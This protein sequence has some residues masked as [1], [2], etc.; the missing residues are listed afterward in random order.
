MKFSA[1]WIDEAVNAAP[2]ERATVADLRLWLSGQNVT[3]HFAGER[4]ADYVTIALYGIAHGLAHDWWT[5]FGGRDRTVSLMRFRS[6][7]LVPDIR[8]SFDGAAFDVYADQHS[9]QNE[10]VRFWAGA[11][12]TM[13]RRDAET[14]LDDLMNEI[15]GRL[16]RC[17][18]SDTSATLR[19]ARVRSSRESDEAQFC[20]AAGALGLD[21]Y[22]IDEMSAAAIQQSENLFQNEALIEF[23]AG[24]RH[25]EKTK[26][27]D[28]VEHVKC[29][30]RYKSHVPELKDIAKQAQAHA[31]VRPS[32]KAWSLGYRRARA[33]RKA[34]GIGLQHRYRSFRDLAKSLGASPAY[35]IA[36]KIDG[37][38]ALRHD[39]ANGLHIHLRS[40]SGPQETKASYLFTFAR[41]VGDAVCF[42]EAELAPV[43]DLHSAHR[44]AA[45]RAFAAD[46]APYLPSFITGLCSRCGPSWTGLQTRWG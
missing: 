30:S 15:L 35:E 13:S 21:P 11:G 8:M 17:G 20:E 27:V 22:A 4:A 36:K 23:I 3:T 14:I 39:Q 24:A 33:M 31:P 25:V 40:H 34:F 43:N 19:W 2:E 29:R 37:I 46:V 1:D 9:Y 16:E 42:P 7:F 5:L 6:G 28:W 18:I 45:G 10:G 32:E 41:A 38:R 44:Q 12:E 26:L